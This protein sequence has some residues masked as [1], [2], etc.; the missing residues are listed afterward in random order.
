MQC[1]VLGPLEFRA[2]AERLRT[3]VLVTA[4]RVRWAPVSADAWR[5]SALAAAVA[6]QAGEHLL[7]SLAS[8]PAILPVP[9]GQ[10]QQAADALRQASLAWRRAGAQWE[11]VATEV[12]GQAAPV[13]AE[14]G[15]LVLRMGRLA[16]DD[17]HWTPARQHPATTR[18]PPHPAADARQIV[19][20]VHQ[21]SDAFAQQHPGNGPGRLHP[22]PPGGP[23][24][25]P[26]PSHS[27]RPAQHH[28]PRTGAGRAG[29]PPAAGGR[30]GPAAARRRDRPGRPPAHH[31]SRTSAL[32][33]QPAT[34]NDHPRRPAAP[35]R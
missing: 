12:R 25:Q 17:P 27:N 4:G 22:P 33:A 18:I 9:P 8:Q 14:I 10:L 34:G 15:D 3:A 13:V 16:W 6:G 26:A 5:W 28:G 20:A 1:R 31:P 11:G 29:D 2:G 23:R 7:R 21:A 24:P 35:W 19:A 32:P 30:P